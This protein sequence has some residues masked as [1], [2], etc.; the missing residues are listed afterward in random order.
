[1]ATQLTRA[2]VAANLPATDLERARSFYADRLGLKQADGAE[3]GALAF[4]AGN[5]SMLYIY[6]RDEPT[7]AEHTVARWTVD[8][9]E[10]AVRDLRARGVEFE[11]YDMPGLKTDERGIAEAE[12]VKGAWFRDSEGNILAVAQVHD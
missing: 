8:D 3:A 2:P 4:E 7:R 1:M 6:E 10:M 11:R 9:I 5:D 12:G